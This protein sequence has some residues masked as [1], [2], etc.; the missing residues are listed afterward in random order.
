MQGRAAF[1]TPCWSAARPHHA[2]CIRLLAGLILLSIAIDS[3]ALRTLLAAAEVHALS[4]QRGVPLRPPLVNRLPVRRW[5]QVRCRED[6]NP[7]RAGRRQQRRKPPLRMHPAAAVHSSI[8]ALPFSL[9]PQQFPPL[10][11]GRGRAGSPAPACA[12]AAASTAAG[13][14]PL[15]PSPETTCISGS[16][17][18][19]S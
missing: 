16:S 2:A 10:S 4:P 6:S 3:A 13:C 18:L 9:S 15:A 14:R 7:T 11:A 1:W 12:S 8:P 17:V 5:G 19:S